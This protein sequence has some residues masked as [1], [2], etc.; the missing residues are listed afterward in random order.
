RIF[1]ASTQESKRKI[2][3]R[4]EK[5]RKFCQPPGRNHEAREHPRLGVILVFHKI[6]KCLL[7]WQTGWRIQASI[8]ND[9]RHKSLK[10]F[11]WSVHIRNYS[12]KIMGKITGN[13]PNLLILSKEETIYR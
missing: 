9:A 12:P 10:R 6:C 3:N 8:V 4:R 1:S 2:S 7:Q 11:F 13:M 5:R